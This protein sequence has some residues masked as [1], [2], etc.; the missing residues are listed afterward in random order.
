MHTLVR[1]LDYL[2]YERIALRSD[3]ENSIKVLGKSA[4]DGWSGEV[5]LEYAPQGGNK[6]N[7]EVD[8]AVQN[9]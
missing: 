6:S 7:G 5:T 4:Q 8:R 3:Q 2:G 1:D 9:I